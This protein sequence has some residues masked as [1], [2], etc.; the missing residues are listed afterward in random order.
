MSAIV[1][2]A[3][4]AGQKIFRSIF[5]GTPSLFTSADLNRQIEALKYQI[6]SVESR[7]GV[8]T[9]MVVL[10][11]LT[12]GTLTVGVGYSYLEV[13]GCSFSPDVSSPFD[14]NL[15]SSTGAAYLILTAETEEV[16][17][18]TDSTHDIAGAK[19]VDGTSRE[20][21]N[22]L[23]YKG[24]ALSLTHSIPDNCIAVLASFTVSDS[25]DVPVYYPNFIRKNSS[26][27]LSPANTIRKWKSG[28][29]GTIGASTLYD[30]AINILD[31]RIKNAEDSISNLGKFYSSASYETTAQVEDGSQYLTVNMGSDFSLEAGKL[32]L[33]SIT[34][35]VTRT[36]SYGVGTYTF[37]AK[38]PDVIYE[39]ARSISVLLPATIEGE[40][41][42]S[43]ELGRL[44]VN[45]VQSSGSVRFAINCLHSNT[46]NLK[47]YPSGNDC[48]KVKYL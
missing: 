40:S 45:V 3:F 24:E 12:G 16:T 25:S 11:Y 22:Q 46:T 42:N 8:L 29:T 33:V 44:L 39:N 13:K 18:Q 23:V 48:V 27:L 35:G 20:A 47:V 31:T 1:E 6:D 43:F 10:P 14:I 9:D 34:V 30:K 38:V 2:K 4:N 36:S 41:T 28:L 7:L 15:T 26:A 19:F 17:Y 37:M 5:K 21:A 32:I